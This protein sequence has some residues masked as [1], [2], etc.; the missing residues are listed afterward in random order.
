MNDN[1]LGER[2]ARVETELKYLKKD[3]SDLQADVKGIQE[4]Q[5]QILNILTQA[6]GVQRFLK[7]GVWVVS[8]GFL[9]AFFSLLP[10]IKTFLA[11]VGS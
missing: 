8:S 4:K 7:F 6:R 3:L 5:D 2:I 11:K 10:S 9:A 1:S